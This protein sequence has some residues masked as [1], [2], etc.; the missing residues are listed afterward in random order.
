M[1]A[2]VTG[3]VIGTFFGGLYYRTRDAGYIVAGM[4]YDNW[5][6]GLSYDLNISDLRPASN[7]RGGLE[8]SVVY[9]MRKIQP[10]ALK[11][12]YCPDYL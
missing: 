11:Y 10:P 2:K 6:V 1:T 5:R 4:D 12:K 3:I 8:I 9:I 7:G